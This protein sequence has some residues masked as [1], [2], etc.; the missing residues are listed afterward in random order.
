MEVSWKDCGRVS[1]LMQTHH[2]LF[3]NIPSDEF[4]LFNNGGAPKAERIVGLLKYRKQDVAKATNVPLGS[5]RYDNKMPEELRQRVTE[6]AI[7]L[8][9]VASFFKD[10]QR[11]LLWFQASN[12][13]LG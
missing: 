8:N 1:Q 7:A 5:V 13:L 3:S 12:P 2:E 6:W 9:L 4:H 10:Q 11:T